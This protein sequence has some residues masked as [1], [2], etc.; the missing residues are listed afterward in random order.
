MFHCSNWVPRCCKIGHVLARHRLADLSRLHIERTGQP[1]GTFPEQ[2]NAVG[3]KIFN[4]ECSVKSKTKS[5]SGSAT[6]PWLLSNQVRVNGACYKRLSGPCASILF[7]GF[8]GSLHSDTLLAKQSKYAEAELLYKR[9][10]AIRENVLGP[11][12]QDVAAVLN[13]QG[14]LSMAQV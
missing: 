5:S 11:E 7:C 6:T 9:S 4:S 2:Q 1:L 10:L 12:H 3:A 13:N 8:N 14:E